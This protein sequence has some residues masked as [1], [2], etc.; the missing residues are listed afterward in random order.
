MEHKILWE[1]IKSI[2]HH[3]GLS[4]SGLA[5]KS[6]LDATTFNKSKQFSSNGTPRWPSCY[7]ISKIINATGMTIYDFADFIHNAEKKINNE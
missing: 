2:A 7:T 4:C 1:A 3:N 5:K 6:G